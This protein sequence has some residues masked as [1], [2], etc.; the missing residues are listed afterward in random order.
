VQEVDGRTLREHLQAAHQRTGI[1]PDALAEAPAIPAGMEGLW[2]DF[3]R[4]HRSRG[5]SGYGPLA[6][7][8]ADLAGYETIRRRRFAPWQVD[9]IRAADSAYLGHFAATRRNRESAK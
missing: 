5:S 8:Y 4:L 7:S 1:M 3:M 9:A 2:S 6:I